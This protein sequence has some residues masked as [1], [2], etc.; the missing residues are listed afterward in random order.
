[1]K[2]T[3]TTEQLDEIAASVSENGVCRWKGIC[4]GCLYQGYDY[5]EQLAIKEKE[6]RDLMAEAGIRPGVF[7]HIQPSPDNAQLHYRN[8][9]EYTFGDMYKGGELCLGLHRKKQFMSVVTTDDCMLVHPDFNV[10]LR[11][12]LDF[13]REHGYEKY[14]KKSHTGLL[15]N[16]IIRRGVRTRELLVSIVTSSDGDFDEQAFVDKLH[17]LELENTIVGISRTFNDNIADRVTVDGLKV[18]EGRDYYMEEICGLKFKVKLFAF[19]QT[20]VEAVE[21]LYIDAV[22]LLDDFGDKNV[23]DLYCGTGTISQ[24]MAGKAA[25]VTGIEIVEDSV[26]AARKNVELNGI[27]NCDFICGDVFETLSGLD[28]KPD[29]I[30]ADPP[31]VGI[32]VD[33]VTKIASYGIPQIVYISCN[34][35]SLA[36]DLAAFQSLGYRVTY[37]KPYDN[38]KFTKHI[39]AVTLLSRAK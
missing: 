1:M 39:E 29:V 19:F 2:N 12:T 9:M 23:F 25:H 4:G 30:V 21:K 6:V 38:F 17:G 14:N 33:A 37:M 27:H 22:S 18:L 20:N 15:R 16:L 3:I 36:K 13:A 11:G 28:E 10:I 31:R 26:E 5:S 7:E 24:I 32:G 34:P 35:V 8:K